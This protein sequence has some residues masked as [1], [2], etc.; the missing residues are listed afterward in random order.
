M[1]DL[2]LVRSGS[3]FAA[4][5]VT[6]ADS[7]LADPD[8]LEE[9]VGAL[10][11]QILSTLDSRDLPEVDPRDIVERARDLALDRLMAEERR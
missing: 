1:I 7:L 6:L 11:Q 5:L 10:A 8:D 9:Y 2:A 4:D 3:D